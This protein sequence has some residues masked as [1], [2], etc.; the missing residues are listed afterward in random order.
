MLGLEGHVEI[1]ILTIV[2]HLYFMIAFYLVLQSL[3]MIL[4]SKC[5][6][7]FT[8]KITLTRAQ[9]RKTKTV[10]IPL[11]IHVWKYSHVYVDTEEL[12]IQ[13]EITCN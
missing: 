1:S 2:S 10:V 8:S 13:Y 12:Y 4:L 11:Y 9:K 3:S 7:S 5:T 6:R